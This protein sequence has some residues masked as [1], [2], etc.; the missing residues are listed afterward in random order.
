MNELEKVM[1]KNNILKIK[2]I[3]IYIINE[4]GL[5]NEIIY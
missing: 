2:G 1:R 4:R 5:D 3:I